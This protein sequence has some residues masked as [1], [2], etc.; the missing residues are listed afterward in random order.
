[1]IRSVGTCSLSHLPDG[2]RCCNRECD[3]DLPSVVRYVDVSN[4]KTMRQLTG[5]TDRAYFCSIS[6]A[7][8]VCCMA[9]KID[10]DR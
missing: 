6:C 1:M 7:D 2:Q 10:G 8:K 3:V 9:E 5:A 4:D